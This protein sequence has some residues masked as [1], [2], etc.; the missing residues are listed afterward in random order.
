MIARVVPAVAVTGPA[1]PVR[2]PAITTRDWL[3]LN[4]DREFFP[5]NHGEPSTPLLSYHLLH[6]RL[7]QQLLTVPQ[8]AVF[9]LPSRCPSVV[10]RA[11]FPSLLS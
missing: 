1:R 10:T 6:T 5:R 8:T 3:V 2:A 9:Y 4:R 11:I 7:Y